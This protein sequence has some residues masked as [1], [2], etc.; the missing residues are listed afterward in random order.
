MGALGALAALAALACS[1]TDTRYG[2]AG[3]LAASKLPPIDDPLVCA[4]IM[5]DAGGEDADASE[6]GEGGSAPSCAVSWRRDLYAKMAGDGPWQCA[7][8][9]CHAPDAAA[10]TI[11]PS[12][13]GVALSALKAY[14]LSTRP[15]LPY[16]GAGDPARSTIDC[17]VAGRCTPAMPIGRGRQLTAAER[18]ALR[19][20]LACGAP[21]N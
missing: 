17:N 3:D 9:S 18:C 5:L 13:P 21:D 6:A 20:W 12:D 11:D 7:T 10:P 4:P 8:A 2:N 15:D 19:A 14:A 16:V 1:T